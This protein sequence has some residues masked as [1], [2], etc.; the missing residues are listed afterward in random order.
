MTPDLALEWLLV[1][2]LGLSVLLGAA[3]VGT[4]VYKL[5]QNVV[6]TVAAL[7]MM[8]IG[9]VLLTSPKWQEVAIKGGGIEATVRALAVKIDKG[10]RDIAAIS[11]KL[12]TLDGQSALVAKMSKD[13]G[14]TSRTIATL[15]EQNKTLSETVSE[16]AKISEHNKTVLTGATNWAEWTPP[17]RPKSGPNST[18]VNTGN[19]TPGTGII[20]A[21]GT[22]GAT[23]TDKKQPKEG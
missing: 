20:V 9:I 12:E 19:F 6:P 15:V 13:L 11:G 10:N 3:A 22:D 14:T 8:L 16:V 17:Y 21:P 23:S 1:A 7:G 2:A 5:I 18:I 4:P